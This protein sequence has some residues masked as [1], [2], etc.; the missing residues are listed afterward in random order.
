MAFAVLNEV[1]NNTWSSCVQVIAANEVVW[2]WMLRLPRAVLPVCHG[3]G[4]AV[5][6]GRHDAGLGADHANTKTLSKYDYRCASDGKIWVQ[7][8][9]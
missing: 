9:S 5:D 6:G 1:L 3:T 2:N 4:W 7:K 8:K